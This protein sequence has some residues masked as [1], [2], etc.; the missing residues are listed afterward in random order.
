MIAQVGHCCFRRRLA[1]GAALIRRWQRGYDLYRRRTINFFFACLIQKTSM[2]SLPTLLTS[3]GRS[4]KSMLAALFALGLLLVAVFGVNIN[5]AP[6]HASIARLL[7]DKL[8]R[9]V[10]LDGSL[11]LE[12]SAHPALLIRQV[13][14][15]QPAGFGEADF[16]SIGELRVALDLLPLLKGQL[17]IEQLAGKD[18]RLL[19]QQHADGQSNWQFAAPSTKPVV[20]EDSGDS[21]YQRTAAAHID[22]QKIALSRLAIEYRGAN[23]KPLFFALDQFDALAPAGGAMRASARGRVEQTLPY[24]LNIE[25]GSLAALLAGDAVWPLSLRLEFLDSVFT[26]NGDL[27]SAKN[28][29]RFGLGTP[30]LAK[31]G[32]LLQMDLPD[33]GAAGIAGQVRFAPGRIEVKDIFGVLGQTSLQGALA[34]DLKSQRPRISGAL[35]MPTLDVQPFFGE[36]AKA[37]P[38]VDLRQLY[39]S[40]AGARFDLQSLNAVDIDLELK[41][42][43]W[44]SLPGAIKDAGLRL[45]LEHGK[46]ALPLQANIAGVNV[47]GNIKADASLALPTFSIDF[48]ASQT[49]IG[50]LAQLLTGVAGI[51]GRLGHFQLGLAAAGNRGQELMQNLS[52]RLM[53]SESKLSYGHVEGGKPV[54]FTLD[55]FELALPARKA[56]QGH[57]RGSLLGS[58]LDAVLA[59]GDLLSS[60]ETGSTPIEFTAQSSGLTARI[61]GTLQSKGE[62]SQS[63]LVFSLGAAKAGDV[64]SWF[65]LRRD[66]TAALV[67]AG[68][69]KQ[70]GSQWK[71]S[72][73]IGQLGRSSMYANI[74]RSEKAGRPYLTALV[75]VANIDVA[76]LEGL[77]APV[78]NKSKK[79]KHKGAASFDIPILPQQLVLTDADVETRVRKIEGAKLEIRDIRFDAKVR[80]GF[81]QT[82]PFHATLAGT[83]FDGALMLDLRNDAPRVQLWVSAEDVDAGRMLQQLKLADQMDARLV[84]VSL[85]LDSRA[86]RLSG[87]IANAQLNGQINGG[88]LILRDKN[89]AS[90]MHIVLHSGVLTAAPGEA[91]KLELAA[92]VEST[93]VAITLRSAPASELVNPTLRVPFNLSVEA[94]QTQLSLSGTLERDFDVPDIE[95]AMKLN[96]SRF[97]SLNKMTRV[98][99]PPWGPW[100]AAGRFRMSAKGYEVSQLKLQVGSSTLNG[101]GTLDTRSGR[102][103]LDV[104]LTAPLIQ[105]DDFPGGSWLKTEGGGMPADIALDQQA[106]RKKASDTSDQVQGLLSPAFLR[107]LNASLKVE[108]ERVMSGRDQLGNGSLLAHIDKGRAEIGPVKLSMPGG[109]ANWS[110]AYEPNERDVLANLKMDV[111]RFDYGVLARRIKPQSEM[112]GRFSL[113]LDVASRAPRLSEI[114]RHGSGRIDFGVWPQN[115]QAGVFD[116]WAVNVLVALL[117]TLD[118]KNNSTVNCAIGRFGLND[119]KLIQKQLVI[120]TTQM[121]VAGN[122]AVNFADEKILMRLQPQAKTAQ[123]LSL[124]TPIEVRGSFSH[125]SVGPNAGD[126]LATIGRLA[127]SLIWVPIK[128]LFEDKVP[129]DGSDVCVLGNDTQTAA[130]KKNK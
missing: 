7:S 102:G 40:L 122:T 98:V 74:D 71:V 28:Q 86:S 37:E 81:M 119:G 105:L 106:L 1:V 55:Q 17:Q 23:G 89:T 79:L 111:D 97:D 82:S 69:F 63:E 73:L 10:R 32:R 38:P 20:A 52:V 88:K 103:K 36:D 42:A 25:S 66:A 56:L 75:D 99:L 118:P 19:L 126:V 129:A 64:A 27:G 67:L 120:D 16:L 57:L 58:P 35:L 6:Y 125:F 130:E 34:I 2:P 54:A 114:L 62:A 61:A 116:M 45:Q 46:L 78:S 123:F 96:G 83:A 13:R 101:Q 117:P 48:A 85:Y 29:L 93:P 8:G 90:A 121:R 31:F 94:A 51:E 108:V 87:L 127:T 128:K 112:A 26:I 113:H 15:A 65:G 80:D 68:S 95:L 39:Q 76:E 11:M 107:T 104:A 59:G 110:L 60:M 84:R 22:I 70:Q 91:V 14:I 9:A 92:A 72:N 100:S 41:V 12:I 49:D 124:S 47:K 5:A 50:G 43:Q 18:V 33:A 4:R 115:M 77:R 44:L 109:T 3:I 24:K 53:L 30:D 21:A